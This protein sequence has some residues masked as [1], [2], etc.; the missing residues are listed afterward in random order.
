MLKDISQTEITPQ[1]SEGQAALGDSKKYARGERLTTKKQ[2]EMYQQ[3]VNE[4]F[5]QQINQHTCKNDSESSVSEEDINEVTKKIDGE[6]T[7][8]TLIFYGRNCL[9]LSNLKDI[10]NYQKLL[11]HK[12]NAL[13]LKQPSLSKPSSLAHQIKSLVKQNELNFKIQIIRKRIRSLE[14]GSEKIVYTSDPKAIS[15]FNKRRKL[16][17]KKPGQKPKG[18]VSVMSLAEINAMMN[19][20]QEQVLDP[21]Q[22]SVISIPTAISNPVDVVMEQIQ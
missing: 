11:I 14:D 15:K 6:E 4:L 16:V 7:D 3:R 19:Y 8:D 21:N 12:L 2:R 18:N 22:S 13:N 10:P 5:Q 20:G 17:Q 1:T 9:Q